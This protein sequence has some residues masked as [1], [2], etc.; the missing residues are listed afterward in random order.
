MDT[1]AK[2]APGEKPRS[3]SSFFIIFAG[4]SVS[5]FGSQLVQFAIV[6]WLTKTSGSASVLAFGSI[7]AILP[8]V[9]LG[10][11]AGAL[12]DRWN[13]RVVMIVSDGLIALAV[14]VLA[15][16]YAVDAVQ[17]WHIY[18]LMF[19]RSIAG[20]FH[21]PAMQASTTLLVP[22]KYLSRVAG[23]N[24]ALQGLVNIA[25]APTGAV[26]LEILPM[27]SILAIDV[28]TAAVAIFVLFFIS[29][30]QPIRRQDTKGKG[31]SVLADIREGLDYMLVWKGGLF[32]MTGAL[33][34]NFLFTPA[35]S[36]TPILVMR[37]FAGGAR[38][39]ALMASVFG[40]GMVLGG[41]IL[42]AW[43][44]FKRRIVTAMSAAIVSGAATI[45]IGLTPSNMFLLALA[46]RFISAFALPIA[47]GSLFA[48]LQAKVPPEMQGR[49]FT[50][51]GSGSAA[52]APLGLA[53]AGPVADAL[54]VQIWFIIGGIG[55][56]GIGTVAFFIPSIMS[57]EKEASVK[58][59]N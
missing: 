9:L 25:A 40:I 13:R 39:Y 31:S 17:I 42:G 34:V 58:A 59:P 18:V 6:W 50:L 5:L 57:I 11:F 30:P 55:L 22:E 33:I 7:V 32:I 26:V 3:M 28:A 16:L 21:W 24:Q 36:M 20:S 4:Q 47:N 1:A 8:Q 10:P 12:V 45:V 29:I 44:G 14:V 56:I 49:I 53:I 46:M 51:L 54:G 2:T 35:A 48:I 43:G 23:L 37:H 41:L 27:Q 38:E 15:V 52:M 19:F